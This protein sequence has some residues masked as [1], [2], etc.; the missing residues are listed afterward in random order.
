VPTRSD[1]PFRRATGLL[2]PVLTDSLFAA[3]ILGVAVC[4]LAI[5]VTLE[6]WLTGTDLLGLAWFDGLFTG[7]LLA[8]FFALIAY[9]ALNYTGANAHIVGGVAERWTAQELT[10]LGS[11]WQRFRNLP[12][13]EGYSKDAYKIDRRVTT[14]SGSFQEKFIA[15]E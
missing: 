15:S 13:D 4:V 1:G 10:K 14:W 7:F 11:K 9:L 2:R 8:V 6:S 3:I 12:F 5:P